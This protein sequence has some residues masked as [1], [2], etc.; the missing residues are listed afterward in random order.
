MVDYT[1]YTTTLSNV[2]FNEE[3]KMN[4]TKQNERPELLSQLALEVVNCIPP[5]Q[6]LVFYTDGSKSDTGRTGSGVLMKSF[7]NPDHSSV[8]RSERVAI[9]ETL[10]LV[11]EAD[12]NDVWISTDSRSS[13]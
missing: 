7:R 2:A 8:F 9:Q 11:L 13:V 1:V 4:F 6:A 3:L 12:E 10:D 5:P